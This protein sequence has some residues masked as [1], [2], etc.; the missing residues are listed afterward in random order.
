MWLEWLE[1]QKYCGEIE[2]TEDGKRLGYSAER[3]V[4]ELQTRK[5]Q[6]ERGRVNL[7]I[8]SPSEGF[9]TIAKCRATQL[10]S[11]LRPTRAAKDEILLRGRASSAGDAGRAGGGDVP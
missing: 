2:I 8:A 4:E 11:Q 7:R 5:L 3:V 9:C 6:L 10:S 1:Q